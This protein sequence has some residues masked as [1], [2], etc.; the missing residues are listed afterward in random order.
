MSGKYIYIMVYNG[1]RL[2]GGTFMGDVI[3]PDFRRKETCC[4]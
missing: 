4:C 1:K 2:A 3:S